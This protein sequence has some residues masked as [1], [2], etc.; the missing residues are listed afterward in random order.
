M[1]EV[2][3]LIFY[4]C[5]YTIHKLKIPSKMLVPEPEDL[6]IRSQL[7]V[8]FLGRYSQL[9]D[10]FSPILPLHFD[11]SFLPSTLQLM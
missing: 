1:N 10:N 11:K 5:I 4:F 3:D 9:Y 7:A 2:V 6:N 8:D